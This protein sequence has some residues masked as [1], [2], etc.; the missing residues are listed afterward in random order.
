VNV[1][2]CKRQ[3]IGSSSLPVPIHILIRKALAGR[4]RDHRNPTGW[5]KY[6][7]A[8]G[9]RKSYMPLGLAVLTGGGE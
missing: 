9:K 6:R 3:T 1:S 2:V 4:V 7:L 8:K 5:K